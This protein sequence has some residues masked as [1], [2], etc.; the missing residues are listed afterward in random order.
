MKQKKLL[1]LTA[2]AAI[3]VLASEG[4][5]AAATASG[6]LSGF[7]IQLYDLNPLDSIAPSVV[8]S[9]T[10]GS[11]VYAYESSTT[12]Y[13]LDSQTTYS[14]TAFGAASASAHGPVAAGAA[15]VSATTVSTSASAGA[16]DNSLGEGIAFL[17]DGGSSASFTLSA[18]TVMVISATSSLSASTTQASDYAGVNAYLQVYGS[19]PSGYQGAVSSFQ[20]LAGIYYD[21]TDTSTDGGDMAVSFVN[22][23]KTST[24]TGTFYGYMQSWARSFEPVSTVPEPGNMA[25]LAAGLGALGLLSRRRARQG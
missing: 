21:A 6:T 5:S 4:A 18:N 9:D 22:A 7:T 11:Y 17:G 14:G 10:Y 3:A 8:F 16:G 23:S 20:V 24:A 12:P 2:V 15:S 13:S 19:S 25:L 1:A